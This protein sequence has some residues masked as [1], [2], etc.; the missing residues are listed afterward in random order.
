MAAVLQSARKTPFQNLGACS[1]V[2]LKASA[3][4]P[5]ATAAAAAAG[6][7]CMFSPK[8][9]RGAARGSRPKVKVT[10]REKPNLYFPAVC[11]ST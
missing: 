2:K 8:A 10:I 6:S 11:G 5:G 3:S 9:A 1:A 4:T 7:S